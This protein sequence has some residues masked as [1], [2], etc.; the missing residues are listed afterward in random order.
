MTANVSNLDAVIADL[1]SHGGRMQETLSPVMKIKVS[2]GLEAE[3]KLWQRRRGIKTEA[4]ALRRLIRA[5]LDSRL[6]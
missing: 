1:R 2:P 6:A 4:E 3:I 5:G